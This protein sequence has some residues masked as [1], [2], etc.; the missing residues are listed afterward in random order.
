MY[1]DV[2]KAKA[3]GSYM[4][5]LELKLVHQ[6]YIRKTTKITFI[7]LKLIDLLLE[8]NTL[9][10]IQEQF[11]NIT[12]VPKYENSSVILAD[13]CTKPRLG[14]ILIRITKFM[15]EF[16]FYPNSDT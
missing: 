4:E 5:A 14:T 1:N 15:T 6:Q 3:I 12:F 2:N 16:I 11:K 13:M 9:S 7:F 8:L 10:F